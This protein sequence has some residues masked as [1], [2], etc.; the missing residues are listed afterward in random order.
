[1]TTKP[2]NPFDYSKDPEL[3]RIFDNLISLKDKVAN[4]FAKAEKIAGLGAV[5]NFN[6]LKDVKFDLPNYKYERE[7]SSYYSTPLD[8]IDDIVRPAIAQARQLIEETRKENAPLEEQNKLLISQVTELMTRIGIPSTYTTYDYPSSRSRTKK[9]TTHTSGYIGDLE[10]ARPKS[11]V[12]SMK[13]SVD[14]YERDYEAWLKKQK[15]DE[16]KAKIAKDEEA[17]QRNI[18]GNPALVATLMKA[19]VNILEEV[20][21]AVPG[22]KAEVIKYCKVQAITNLKAMPD[23][24]F[25]LIQ[26]I[27]DL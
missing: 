26:E 27:Q 8:K 13:Y 25:E 20:Q 11:N 4:Q 7:K 19:G 12:E 16:L 6:K 18:L 9:S 5:T 1:M 2:S 14:I 15:E 21:K 3:N 22:Q 23:P 17:V 24:D 10:R